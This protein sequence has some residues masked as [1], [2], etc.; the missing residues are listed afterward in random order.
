MSIYN[1]LEIKKINLNQFYIY[2]W[3]DLF[4]KFVIFFEKN[5]VILILLFV[6][7]LNPLYVVQE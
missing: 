2:S 4:Q 1:I 6:H 3:Y 5:F 7:Y